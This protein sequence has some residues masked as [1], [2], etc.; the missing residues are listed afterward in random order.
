MNHLKKALRMIGQLGQENATVNAISTLRGID[1][2]LLSAWEIL[3]GELDYRT[4][5]EG[6]E[7][8][9]PEEQAKMEQVRGIMREFVQTVRTSGPIGQSLEILRG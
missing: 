2:Q 4:Q 5:G 8:T 3:D 1:H 9:S 6:F 7:E